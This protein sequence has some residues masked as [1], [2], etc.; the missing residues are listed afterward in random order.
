[1]DGREL[2]G[3]EGVTR[4]WGLGGDSWATW[5]R[6]LLATV[7]QATVPRAAKPIAPPT[8]WPVLSRLEA[9]PRSC[10]GPGQGDQRE[11]HEQQAQSG[12]REQDGDQQPLYVVCTFTRENQ[13]ISS[14]VIAVPAKMSD[15]GRYGMIWL[16]APETTTTAAAKGRNA[17]PE[18]PGCSPAR[19]AR[20]GSGRRDPDMAVA[21]TS[22]MR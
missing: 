16:T 5:W 3:G 20:T 12:A 8:C 13:Y 21:T 14:L 22:M 4:R 17:I 15:R 10:R 18:L 9:R 2:R 6:V 19:S 7:V 11:R 1:M